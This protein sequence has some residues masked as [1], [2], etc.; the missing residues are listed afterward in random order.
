M[1]S[2]TVDALRD[3]STATARAARIAV[4]EL[5]REVRDLRRLAFLA[6]EAAGG[7]VEIPASLFEV[8]L[9]ASCRVEYDQFPDRDMVRFTTRR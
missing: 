2:S 3:R 7:S 8:P 5:E 6:I 9:P 1:T 4:S